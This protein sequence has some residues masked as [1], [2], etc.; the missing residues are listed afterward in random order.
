MKTENLSNVQ[1]LYIIVKNVKKN[2]F[3]ILKSAAADI[4]LQTGVDFLKGACYG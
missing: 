4:L 2:Q 1:V 3:A